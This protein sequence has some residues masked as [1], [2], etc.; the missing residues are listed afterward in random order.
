MRLFTGLDV[1]AEVVANL[2]ELFRRL[3]PTARIG[4]SPLANLHVTTKFIGEWPEDRLG[5]LTAGLAGIPKRGA[6]PVRIRQVG[7][8]P[9]PRTPRN[10]WCGIEAPGLA[11]LAADTDSATAALGIASER[12]PFSPHLTLA[13]VTAAKTRER[14]DLQP[15][16]EAITALP[17][18]EFGAFQ[19]DRFFL[20]QSKLRPTGSVYTKLAEF[21]LTR[22]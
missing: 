20:Y 6:I 12:R 7:F 21:P 2:E 19:A 22:S 1:P 10:F 3:K 14:V 13:R 16:R 11:E 8:F 15:L 17:T 18:L 9:N 4:W 5:E